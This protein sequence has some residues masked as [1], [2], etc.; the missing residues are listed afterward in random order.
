MH[1]FTIKSYAFLTVVDAE[2]LV[3]PP[4]IVEDS[5]L[6]LRELRS[7]KS[8]PWVDELCEGGDELDVVSRKYVVRA[9]WQQSLQIGF[10]VLM[11][12]QDFWGNK[13][14]TEKL[15]LMLSQGTLWVHAEKVCRNVL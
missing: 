1:H 12:M 4:E 15:L 3:R 5:R 10:A 8:V 2:G 13:V 11:Y 9:G 14:P 6:L 7:G